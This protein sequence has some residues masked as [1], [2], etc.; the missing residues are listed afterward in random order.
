MENR[1]PHSGHGQGDVTRFFKFYLNLIFGIGDARH[2]E[3]CV[4]IH[5]EEYSCMHDI[6]P[7]KGINSN[8]ACDLF[9]F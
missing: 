6:L 3:F 1:L 9:K 8:L 5:T 2:F 7:Q 4:L